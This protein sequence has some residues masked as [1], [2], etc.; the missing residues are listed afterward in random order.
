VGVGVE[1]SVGVALGVDDGRG[2]GVVVGGLVALAVGDRLGVLVA[3]LVE[4]DGERPGASSAAVEGKAAGVIVTNA[5]SSARSQP[6]SKAT[7]IVAARSQPNL[8]MNDIS[9][10]VLF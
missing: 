8:E 7:R 9:S 1:L 4:P 6:A 5:T 10:I 2:V 3:I